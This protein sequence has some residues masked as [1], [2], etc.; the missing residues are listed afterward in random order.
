[1]F[2]AHADPHLLGEGSGQAL[3]RVV[4]QMY[5]LIQ[6]F[7]SLISSHRF[8]FPYGQFV[9]QLILQYE[10]NPDDRLHAVVEVHVHLVIVLNEM[11]DHRIFFSCPLAVLVKHG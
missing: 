9:V 11:I 4:A 8:E 5:V 2:T 10:F 1:M 7:H 3:R 6:I